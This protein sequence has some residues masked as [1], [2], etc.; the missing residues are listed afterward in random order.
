M[1]TH[2]SALLRHYLLNARFEV[3]PLRG[4]VEQASDLPAGSTVTVTSSPRKGTEATLDTAERLAGIGMRVVPHLAA[5]MIEDRRALEALLDR[6]A[7]LGI[8]EV[9]VVAGDVDKP[10]G[11]FGDSLALLRAM[12]ELGLRPARVGITGY[13]ERHSFISDNAT[14]QAMSEKAH[15]ADYIVSQICY[16]PTTIATWLRSVRARGITLPVHIGAPGVVD[17]AKLLRISLKIGLGDSVRYLRSQHSV[18]SRL[19]TRYTPEELLTQ[20][21]PAVL[22][23]ANRIAGWHFFTFNEVNRTREWSHQLAARVQE[24]PA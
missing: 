6:T 15:H 12:T 23:P 19:L 10:V 17:A 20:L 9:F 18:L 21:T 3:L 24:V 2:E 1:S 5:R 4:V 7:G 14:I 8:D 22:D 13:P 16:D 11:E